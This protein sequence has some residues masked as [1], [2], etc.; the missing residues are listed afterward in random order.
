MR[1]AQD[2]NERLKLYAKFAAQRVEM[3]RQLVEQSR[4]GR[5]QLIHDTLEDYSNI[6]DAIDTVA[7]DAL[8]RK[9]EIGEGMK[10]VAAADKEMLPKLQKIADSRPK[11]LTLYEFMLTQAIETTQDSLS[12]ANEDLGGRAQEVAA[13]EARDKKELESMMQPKDLEAKRAAEKKAAAETN[14]RKPPTLLRKGE[15]IKQR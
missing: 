14:K 10:A 13:K 2:P 8:G 11:D 15:K 9:L 1:L 6:L 3:V 12:S 7:D 5:S 4:P